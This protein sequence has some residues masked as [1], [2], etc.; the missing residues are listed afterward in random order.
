MATLDAVRL[1]ADGWMRALGADLW[2]QV[3]RVRVESLQWSLAQELLLRGETV[4]IDW[5]V[6]SREERDRLRGWCRD[7]GVAVELRVLDAPMDELWRRV[8][9]RNGAPGE[10]TITREHLEMFARELY[11]RPTPEELELFDR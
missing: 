8:D 2:D 7:H 6:W 9:A 5:G 3:M 4:A 1:S 11:E 10:T